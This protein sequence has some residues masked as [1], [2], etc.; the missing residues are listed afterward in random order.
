MGERRWYARFPAGFSPVIERVMAAHDPASTLVKI[1]EESCLFS[2]GSGP[3]NR[4]K[5][6]FS[7]LYRAVDALDADGQS[8]DDTMDAGVAATR[9][10]KR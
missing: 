7:A 10:A 9:F 6:S 8:P 5:G 1:W 4:L 2:S 3:A